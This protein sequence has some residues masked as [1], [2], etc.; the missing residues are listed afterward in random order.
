MPI[1]HH[2]G[3]KILIHTPPFLEH[4]ADGDHGARLTF[5][6]SLAVPQHG[7]AC[8][9]RA[10]DPIRVPAREFRHFCGGFLAGRKGLP[11]HRKR[12]QGK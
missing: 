2:G 3:N 7:L 10:A 12:W 8:I 6:R 4:V 1:P 5:P 11:C 9:A